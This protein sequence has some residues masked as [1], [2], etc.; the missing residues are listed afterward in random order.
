MAVSPLGAPKPRLRGVFHQAAFYAALGAGLVLIAVAPS[1][2][3]AWALAAYV[4][5]LVGL[6]GISAL[7]HR[8][9]WSP[10][11]RMLMRRLDHSAI[12]VLIAGT[13]T[14]FCV[15][16]MPHD[17]GWRLLAVVWALAAGGV[18]KAVAWPHAPKW[19]SAIVYVLFG[20]L[21]VPF[22]AA[23]IGTAGWGVFG[24]LAAGG[25]LYIA[26]AAIYA[27]Q[28]PNPLPEVFGYH[29]IFHVLVIV[30]SVL[31]FAAVGRVALAGA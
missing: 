2:R 13:Y 14:P 8:L 12:F 25:A 19:L 20:L 24:L 7:Y 26:G 29:E 1:P 3:T 22:S 18:L 16:A 30:A 28:R 5:S 15:V 17:F 6:Y 21:I 11:K 4:A 23:L 27:T 10:V 31:H 9:D